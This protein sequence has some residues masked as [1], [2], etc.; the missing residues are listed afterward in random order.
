MS[1]QRSAFRRGRAH[2]T[3]RS[4]KFADGT[5]RAFITVG[6][7]ATIL[8]VLAV[9]VFLFWVVKDLFLPASIG[10]PRRLADSAATARVLDTGVD[11]YRTILWTLSESG[12]LTLRRVHDGVVMR[13][14]V[15]APAGGPGLTAY[16]REPQGGRIALGYSDGSVRLGR[17]EFVTSFLEADGVG[18]ELRRLKVDEVGALGEGLAQRTVRGQFRVQT[19]AFEFE[20]PEA[21][22][23]GSSI[24]SLARS[25]R[26]DE[27]IVAAVAADGRVVLRT[28]T[29]T[30]SILGE[31]F[32]VSWS[33]AAPLP[34]QP[35]RGPARFTQLTDLG[36]NLVLAWTD[37]TLE[38]WVVRDATK[39]RLAETLD[40]AP[41]NGVELSSLGL[42]L[43]GVTL[44]SGRS[45]GKVGGWFVTQNPSNEVDGYALREVHRFEGL[46]A[47]PVISIATSTRERIFA[48]GTASGRAYV[49]YMTSGKRL[50]EVTVRDREPVQAL[51][52][53]P[54][55]DALVTVTARGIAMR[56]FVPRHPEATLGS[57]FGATWYERMPEPTHT[58]QSS[59]GT[60]DFE[61]K[62]SL[63]PL[64]FGTIKATVYS[65][66]LAVP[67]A[68]LA[69]IY[70]SEFLHARTKARIKP[71]VE[72]MASLPSVV[73]GFLAAIVI[74]PAVE[75]VVP[76][77]VTAL[78]TIPVA[79]LLAAHLW[80]ALPTQV[81][82]RHGGLRLPLA[83]LA[84]AG[85]VLAAVA[86]GP[87]VE[88]L[89]FAGDFR[90]WLDG[91]SPAVADGSTG[92]FVLLLPVSAVLVAFFVGRHVNARIAVRTAHASHSRA[93][94]V[95]LG[96]FLVALAASV[97]VALGLA[98]LV[99]HAPTA[100]ALPP[101]DLRA[102]VPIAGADLSPIGT[103]DQR[104]SLVVGFVMG[105][106]VI[107][108][109]YTIAEDALSSVPEHLRAASLG[110]GATPW[111]TA[112]RVIVPTAMSG[113]F[114]ACMVGLGR[115]VGETMIVLMAAGGTA[116]MNMNVFSGFRT[117]SA[118]IATEL[119][120]A[121]RDSTHY[122]TLFLAALVLFA[123]TF[124]INTIA[125]SVRQRFRRRAYQ[126]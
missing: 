9:F 20:T 41:E 53:A 51:A 114:S 21:F 96:K 56:P 83:F 55:N 39:P 6:G 8:A 85:G 50:G 16:A 40:V 108:I 80:Q 118:N 60:D 27:A 52:I 126:L 47:S 117:L 90:L 48:V 2:S 29:K 15:L 102:G 7:L 86:F 107:P 12:T 69:A 22:A 91:K 103:F 30:P 61:P 35:G 94:L 43:G 32:D 106:A 87:I 46:E 4:T 104:N 57:L 14:Q 76:Q 122:R 111:Q 93:G 5:A 1:E 3:R 63:M 124:V 119:P 64:I 26:D 36:S 84:L 112:V 121:V 75:S 79:I 101:F 77:L 37:G 33:A 125:E 58:W 65:M 13:E 28:M 74:A 88:R 59:A 81:S 105:F 73:L 67:L 38:R 98:W 78:F 115:A 45:D 66:L 109:I 31:G 123:L 82:V 100:F 23:A 34:L 10:E 113:L 18:E 42:L 89:L 11:E 44:I 19:P 95:H 99:Y 70:T 25:T 24:V 120:E 49:M 110:C 68:L 71:L 116:V 54:K 92:W 62:L 17:L 72:L 97:V